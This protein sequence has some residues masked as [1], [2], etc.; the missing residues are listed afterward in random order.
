MSM[1][2][3]RAYLNNNASGKGKKSA[4]T[5]AK[6]KAEADHASWLKSQGLH[7]DQLAARKKNFTVTKPT[8]TPPTKPPVQL[9]N[10]L[11][12][13]GGFRRSIMDHLDEESPEVKKAILDKASRLAPAYSKGAYQYISPGTEL[14]D[15][16]K[17]K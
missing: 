2:M 3:E 5:A 13:K 1:H 17:K 12:V 15:I 8:V 7:P 14:S 6:R 11:K 16:G 9:S 4:N 10:N